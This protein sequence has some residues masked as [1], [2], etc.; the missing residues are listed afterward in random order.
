MRSQY[1]EWRSALPAIVISALA[2]TAC[3]TPPPP[4]AQLN[5]AQT[6]IA[7]AQQ[8]GAQQLAPAQLQKAQAKLSGAQA[9]VAQ[10]EMGQAKNLAEE[11][12][13]DAIYA[14]Q[15]ALAQ[16]AENV[17]KEL[18]RARPTLQKAM[19]QSQDRPAR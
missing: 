3:Q 19:E 17:Q 4:T 6:A 5:R 10:K 11:S 2:L 16:K 1:P 9:A 14:E 7:G 18:Q 13:M 8:D 12:E 15:L